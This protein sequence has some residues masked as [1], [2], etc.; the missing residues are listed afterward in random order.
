MELQQNI[1]YGCKH[2]NRNCKFFTNCCNKIFDCRLCHDEYF[3]NNA[4][5]ELIESSDH[6]FAEYLSELKLSMTKD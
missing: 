6:D 2:Y 5:M 1:K 3:E 4:P